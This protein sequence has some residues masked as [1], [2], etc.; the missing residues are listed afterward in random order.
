[1]KGVV[2]NEGEW[3]NGFGEVCGGRWEIE[4]LK[5]GIGEDWVW[6]R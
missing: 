3:M 6:R 2:E 4:W 1:M 5:V